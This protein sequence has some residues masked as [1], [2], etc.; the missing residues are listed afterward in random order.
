MPYYVRPLSS[1]DY[2]AWYPLWQGYLRYYK[3]EI[4]DEVSNISF[5]RIAAEDGGIEGFCAIDDDGEMLG[6]VTYLFHPVTWAA[7]PRCYLEDLFTSEKS[8]GKGVGRTLIAAVKEA[9]ETEGADQ[10]YWLTQEF[11]YAGRT[12]YDKVAKRTPFIKYMQKI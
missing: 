5:N 10:V 11:N 1:T 2:E 12:L 7:D 6:F 4:S 3:T 9:A 8:R